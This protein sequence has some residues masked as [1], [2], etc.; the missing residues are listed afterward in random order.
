MECKTRY[1]PS[2]RQSMNWP[3]LCSYQTPY[4]SECDCC[5]SLGG[6]KVVPVHG[7]KVYKERSGFAPL[8]LKFSNICEWA[9]TRP[10]RFTSPEMN[11]LYL[12]NRWLGAPES[13]SDRLGEEKHFSPYQESNHDFS[14]MHSVSQTLHRPPYPKKEHY[15]YYYYY[16]IGLFL[17][18]C[19][20]LD[21]LRRQIITLRLFLFLV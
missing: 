20:D 15:Y 3:V 1:S 8:I 7:M 18:L 21:I 5:K 10:G 4:K 17:S 6:I 12:L 16:Y 19:S 13:L 11:L 9:A 14:V 2:P